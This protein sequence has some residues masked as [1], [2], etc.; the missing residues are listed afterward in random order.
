MGQTNG[1]VYDDDGV[2]DAEKSNTAVKDVERRP[3][4]MRN[5]GDNG[6]RDGRGDYDGGGRDEV[7]IETA[8]LEARQRRRTM[9]DKF[10]GRAWG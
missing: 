5:D 2:G 7:T 3:E 4:E 1:G 8:A 9:G 10:Q 6:R